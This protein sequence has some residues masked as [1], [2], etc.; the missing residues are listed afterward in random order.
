[1]NIDA[2]VESRRAVLSGYDFSGN[3]CSTDAFDAAGSR[4]LRTLVI[5]DAD[6]EDAAVLL[7]QLEP[8]T[9][10]WR[11]DARSDFADTLYNALSGGYEAL[12]FVGHGQPGSITLGGKALDAEDFTALTGAQVEA[13][14]IHFWSCM[15]GSGA[16]GRAFVRHIAQAFDTVVTAFSGLVGAGNKGGSWLPDVFSRTDASVALPFVNALAYQ[17]TLQ[18]SA[19]KLISVVTATGI[20]VQVRL[21]AGTVI[22]NADL[23]LSFDPAQ[24][25][26]TG[27]TGNPALTGWIWAANPDPAN[28][29]HLLI[30]G[31]STSFT[32]I[33]S[34]SDIVLARISFT[35][36]SESTEF[37]ASLVDRTGLALGDSPVSL[38]TL[39]T[40]DTIVTSLVPV[41]QQFTP[42]GHLSYV[43]GTTIA[44]DFPVYAT[45]P[46]GDTI[47]YKASV[48]QM[49]GTTFF[50]LAGVPQ[51][52][53]TLANGHLTGS[54][55]VPAQAAAGSYV[56]RLLADD[57]IN[58]TNNGTALDVPFS[59][60]H[61]LTINFD[62]TPVGTPAGYE[63]FEDFF[64]D[65]TKQSEG[66]LGSLHNL[67]KHP[68][69]I[70][71]GNGDGIP[72]RF[73]WIDNNE[74]DVSGL[75]TWNANGLC[76]IGSANTG[77]EGEYGR[78]AYDAQGYVV[79]LYT[80]SN[81]G[82]ITNITFN[83]TGS[84]SG[85]PLSHE[86]YYKFQQGTGV[87]ATAGDNGFRLNLTADTDNI[88]LT[89][90]AS[91]SWLNSAGQI[92]QTS[93]GVL[94]FQDTDTSKAGPE[95][96]TARFNM[97]NT[98]ALVAD[99]ADADTLP[100][101][102]VFRD[103]MGNDVSVPLVWHAKDANN[104]IATFTATVK[105]S[106]NA[107]ITFS[108][109]LKDTNGDSKPDTIAG[110]SGT[111][112]FNVPISFMD[113]NSDGK[114]DQWR[115]IE[116]QTQSGRV[117]VDASGNP[118]G[119]YVTWNDGSSKIVIDVNGQPTTTHVPASYETFMDFVLVPAQQ[120]VAGYVASFKVDEDS[121][122][123]PVYACLTD[124]NKDGIPD[125][126]TESNGTG[127]GTITWDANGIW[128][129]H[130]TSGSGSGDHYGR[131]AYDATGDGDVVGL[132]SFDL[133]PY[134]L[135]PDT[136]SSD[137]LVSTF[138]ISGDETG[139]LY[140][141][142]GNGVIDRMAE[143]K[144]WKDASGASNTNTTN[145]KLI[146][147]DAAHWTANAEH[148][149]AFGKQ[150]DNLRRPTT[151]IMNG[152][153]Q[154][155][156]WETTVT[157]GV[158]ATIASSYDN[159]SA[160]LTIIDTDNDG[161]P[162][163]FNYSEVTG[164]LTTASAAG[165]LVTFTSAAITALIE[166]STD[167]KDVFSG[168]AYSAS[169][170]P[171]VFLLPLVN[172][173]SNIT[174]NTTFSVSGAPFSTESYY[175]FQS[176]TGVLAAIGNSGF[177]FNLTADTDNNPL[178][179]NASW[180]WLN[181]S[182]QISETSAGVLTFQDTDTS[183]AGPERWSATFNTVNTG[184]L[185]AD[186]ADANTLP[187]GF[188]VNDDMGKDVNVPL[189]W[190][191][192]DGNN[193]IATFTATVKDS[194]N[195]DITFSGVLKD[196][197]SDNNPD[198]ISGTW[199]SQ[200]FNLLFSFTDTNSDGKPDHFTTTESQTRSGRVQVDAS[201]NPAGLYLNNSMTFDLGTTG[202]VLAS[203]GTIVVKLATDNGGMSTVN[204]SVASLTFDG[205]HLTVPLSGTDA[206][207]SLPYY[208]YP[209]SGADIFVRVPAGVVVGQ[210]TDIVKA[211]Q[212]GNMDNNSYLLSPMTVVGS[213]SGTSGA[214]WVTGTAGNDSIAAGAGNDIMQ[215]SA[216]NDTVDA[217]DGYDKLYL[218]LS[219]S[220][221]TK[222]LD[223]AGALH[224]KTAVTSGGP[225]GTGTT[226]FVE[227][228]RI[229][230]AAVAGSFQI[231]KMD[232]AG[233]SVA[234]TM[235]LK[236]A[237]VIAAA[238]QNFQ[239]KVSS[240][241]GQYV[242]GTPWDD[243]INLDAASSKDLVQVFGDSG[244]DLLVLDLGAGYSKMGVVKDGAA[245]VLKGTLD[246]SGAI[247]ELG[248]MTP[249]QSPSG[250][251]A[252]MTVGTGATAKSFMVYD[253]ES[254]RFV[255]GSVVFDVD[256]AQLA[257]I[258]TINTTGLVSGTPFSN[259]GYYKF[260]SG[261]GV[262]A[263]AGDNGFRLNLTADT[264]NNP[265]TFNASW[266]WL[267]ASGQISQ[268]SAGVLTFQNTDPS[269]AG[270]EYWR[271]TFDT[272]NTGVLLAD[273]NADNL[274]DGF[275]TKDDMGNDVDVPLVW[276]AKD[277]NNAIATFT[278][279]MK[280]GHNSDIVLS[281]ELK[282]IDGDNKPD[283]VAGTS[284]T[285]TFSLPFSFTDTNS[286]GI[287]D[288]W[289]TIDTRTQSGRVQ[290]DASGNPA[291]LYLSS[292]NQ[293]PT[294]GVTISGTATQGQ[295]LTAA[296]TLADADGL[297]TIGYQWQ[298]DGVTIAGAVGSTLLLGAAQT[299]KVI[300]VQ[301]SYTDGH[302]T[303]E[304][305]SSSATAAVVGTQSGIVQDGYL[306]KAL[307]WV[308][309]N[310][311]GRWDAGEGESWTL[312]DS[313]GQFTGLVGTGT[314]RITANP[315]DPSGT[316]D[317]STGKPFTGNY[318]A[319]SGSA[320]VNPL[321]TLV[322][323]ALATTDNDV[324]KANEAVKTALGL[325][326]S[327][328]LKTYDALAEANK[329]GASS[330]DLA[331]AIKVQSAATQ[332]ANIMDIATSAAE[333]GGA[334]ATDIA[335][336]AADVASTLI[337]A[338]PGSTI[339]LA[340]STVISGAIT[341]GLA[342]V[343]TQP[344]ADTVAALA[345]T[346]AKVN[347]TVVAAAAQ[348]GGATARESLTKM[349]QA[350]IVA[351]DVAQ[352]MQNNNSFDALTSDVVNSQVAAASSSVKDIFKNHAPTGDVTMTG[353]ATQGHTLT[354]GDTLADIDG[355]GVISYKW[356][357]LQD[358][359]TWSDIDG[360]TSNSLT[361]GGAQ[362]DRQVR[363]M[364]SYTDGAG[365][366]ETMNSNPTTVASQHTPTGEVT[367]AGT[368]Q[369]GQTLSAVP[370]TL[371]DVDGLGTISYQWQSGGVAIS[372]ATKNTYA[373]TAS[374]V[375]KTITLK[376]SYI[377]GGGTHESVT[378]GETAVVTPLSQTYGITV[379]TKYWNSETLIKGV[380]LETGA[381]T[382]VTGSVKLNGHTAGYMTLFPVLTPDTAAK[383]AVDLLDAIA[384]LKSIV[385]L[386]TL[387]ANQHIAADFNQDNG[388]D[389]NDA[390]GILKHVVG[391]AAPTPEWAFVAKADLSPDPAHAISVDVIADTTVDLVG[392]LR[393]DVD[394]SWSTLPH[395]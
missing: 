103:D 75:I 165:K 335:K 189:V 226:T 44:L 393:G 166:S 15:T 306:S 329:T 215:W 125:H 239:L 152:G 190:Q 207:S 214:D 336:V 110:T 338:T 382:D 273:G 142:D 111:Q 168:A 57:N 107:D 330:A 98:G 318:S 285:Q 95:Q 259:E 299:N 14:S 157:N 344:T 17:H 211:W 270:P 23:V 33:N 45:D 201:G 116:S 356:Q 324:A 384:I 217:G 254:F 114:D 245:Y 362:V 301:A 74:Q 347:D 153:E 67:D 187:D 314:I 368:A 49:V 279:I 210:Q 218:P 191:A 389:L 379:N 106:N 305:V 394:G 315:A 291:G 281:G 174:I 78:V 204:V 141:D 173:S 159:V 37:G 35:R 20:D 101:G 162:D 51:I 328:D 206:V 136:N 263:T 294:G 223:A 169:S 64:F 251:G 220:S 372:G 235:I 369:Q 3:S 10:L 89:F 52:S 32:Q 359:T 246:S 1:M 311:N 61:P 21:T 258:I 388:V 24:A 297:G 229:T 183:K 182:G 70:F 6:I 124:L 261:A 177:S 342:H 303:V 209:N 277:A 373:L 76:W 358:G 126:F 349:V 99:G 265:L 231:Q 284:G 129:G 240:G 289:R 65:T 122:G 300:T 62:G 112:T 113:T 249:P 200:T 321:T 130:I 85:T 87:L 27:T 378:S 370:D 181:P 345:A 94:T 22:D 93:T 7:E 66:Y 155:I 128:Y 247:V 26:Y 86:G 280:D 145:Y 84:V 90:N 298:A 316:I 385:G 295:T 138:A 197:N 121:N 48:G 260:N 327:V 304:H 164:G 97:V 293:P 46:N 170:N 386:T 186:G 72:D 12:H 41:W 377:D 282:D 40:L 205:K 178:T 81:L 42:P 287:P 365:K 363:I 256:P 221:F 91:W 272:G 160:L 334:S 387:N 395:L 123:N 357:V 56:F 216:G 271:A 355:L 264:D 323:A 310:N 252:T 337:G 193:V 332:V 36:Q 352:K 213:G 253:I 115:V 236:N 354:A 234:Q 286:D 255:S 242:S 241:G 133:T 331:K 380:V 161:Q 179:F 225:A 13:P 278:A 248:R 343:V 96:W 151:L 38:G 31:I 346:A 198:T 185:L 288:H 309:A 5:A 302:G 19:L 351:Q 257:N 339:N 222:E 320:V 120:G 69:D 348:T 172:N 108:G 219:A 16:K 269:K 224:I 11:L 325:D 375:G 326:S 296:H 71:D 275:V 244:K 4:D 79:G 203:S 119:L 88:P 60:I 9:E 73:T 53:L 127:S 274:P 55:T 175:K 322:V 262:L 360:A 167:Q 154:T 63:Y 381:Q 102:F 195:A 135:V 8:G 158:L 233:T 171:S 77:G 18:A 143:V 227:A 176:G 163:H 371:K 109:V 28:S 50:G 105:D 118:A 243:Q 47:T 148:E 137:K 59:V 192:K 144:T 131:F 80:F 361:L 237:E 184:L 54:A 367:I 333:G 230:K 276:H 132:Y 340:D 250:Y 58:D 150:T 267:N 82:P 392:I 232:A 308:D 292:S 212:V 283:T 68:G 134:T 180:N 353:T 117:Q 202:A 312:T 366:L 290:V 266:S 313:T 228:Y 29:A 390:I 376:E 364:A 39:P 268:T 383:G 317:I 188:V 307:V 196:T 30:S 43:S 2:V 139:Y 238:S 83:T 208:L 319:P 199:G 25:S 140:D 350:Q 149:L 104:V 146:W 156:K 341:S 147:S 194:N 92:S 34:T 391:L 374:E 100:D